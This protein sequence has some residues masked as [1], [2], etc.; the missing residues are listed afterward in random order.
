MKKELL[1]EI[2]EALAEEMADG[3][4]TSFCDFGI[5]LGLDKF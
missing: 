5:G 4:E 3:Q 2:V 1:L